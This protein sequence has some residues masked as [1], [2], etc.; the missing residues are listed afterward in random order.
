M[1]PDTVLQD[2]SQALNQFRDALTIPAHHDVIRAGCIQFFEFAFEL[3]WK[4]VK[5]VAEDASLDPGGSPKSCI[6]TAFAQE[7]INDE[8]VWLERLDSRN[9]MSHT[10]DAKEA[11][12]IYEKLNAYIEPF[13][14]LLP[15]ME[16]Q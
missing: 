1:K 7:W 11:L 15:S 3:A 2:F 9:R 8:R 5:A 12:S 14:E 10:C 13:A 4:S 6:K 16:K